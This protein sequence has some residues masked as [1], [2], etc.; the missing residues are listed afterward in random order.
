[1]LDMIRSREV[2]EAS[3]DFTVGLEEEFQI[4]DPDTR[5]LT[6]RFEELR[7][8]AESDEILSAAI[9][10]EL[11]SSEIEIRSGR[12][13][14]FSDALACQHEARARLFRLAE[15]RGLVLAA[16]GTHPWSPW[17]EQHI[18]D[19]DHYQRLLEGLGYVARR[20]NTFSLHVHVGIRGPDRA[21]AVCD[22][23]RSVL[24][25]LLAI[26]ASSPF[27][28]GHDSGLASARSQ[29]FT[30]SFPRCG[31]PEPFGYLYK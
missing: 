16:T 29:I 6:Q 24:P 2:F 13:S 18:I 14:T 19:T 15:D 3:E 28:D 7:D 1:M 31:I 10:G 5:A 25:E 21:I 27:L 30:K 12:G 23:L 11:I 8:A 26:S 4:L 9:S 17:Q 20:N 22:R